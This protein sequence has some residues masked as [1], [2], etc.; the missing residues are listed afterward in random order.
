MRYKKGR[1]QLGIALAASWPDSGTWSGWHSTAGKAFCEAL[2]IAGAE[3]AFV[4]RK[5]PFALPC[6]ITLH[7]GSGPHGLSTK[8]RFDEHI[9]K[10]LG[11]SLLVGSGVAKT[12]LSRKWTLDR[13]ESQHEH[14]GAILL[15]NRPCHLQASRYASVSSGVH[16]DCWRENVAPRVRL[17]LDRF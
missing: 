3:V 13:G 11:Q 5:G 12:V 9:E 1:Y 4:R 16:G 8:G 15:F 6:R 17:A 2:A 10:N 14:Q 7:P